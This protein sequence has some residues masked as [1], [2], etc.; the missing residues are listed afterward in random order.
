M[1]GEN[2]IYGKSYHKI[3]D[4]NRIIIPLSTNVEA[5]EELCFIE[6]DELTFKICSLKELKKEIEQLKNI[7][8]S[9]IEE[10]EKIEKEITKI[11]FFINSYSIVDKERRIVIPKYFLEKYNIKKELIFQGAYNH[12]KVFS[13]D[14]N[15]KKY[16]KKLKN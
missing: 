16:M 1:F 11:T 12:I 10:K 9:S 8:V 7:K 14:E 15:Y 13:S 6:E 3:I 2:G 4:K 5:K